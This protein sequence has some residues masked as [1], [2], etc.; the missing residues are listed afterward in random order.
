MSP[1]SLKV[2]DGDISGPKDAP[3]HRGEV[4]GRPV[5]LGRRGAV[6][7]VLWV[8]SGEVD[9][10]WWGNFLGRCRRGA[11]RG[12]WETG[13]D[14]ETSDRNGKHEHR[15]PKRGNRR[16][17]AAPRTIIHTGSRQDKVRTNW[18]R[19]THEDT[20]IR[21]NKKGCLPFPRDPERHQP[22]PAQ[23]VSELAPQG[24]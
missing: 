22:P 6:G 2:G 7:G 3:Q 20:A 18:L 11:T 15:G 9:G 12:N 21:G 10:R 1:E 13:L 8:A 4:L 17:L 16:G 14:S 19:R 24:G 5:R 23:Q